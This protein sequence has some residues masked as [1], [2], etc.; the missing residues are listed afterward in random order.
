[1]GLPKGSHFWEGANSAKEPAAFP[2]KLPW[3]LLM[4]LIYLKFVSN[5]HHTLYGARASLCSS[6]DNTQ[7]RETWIN[8]HKISPVKSLMEESM[9]L[10][11]TQNC[12]EGN[13]VMQLQNKEKALCSIFLSATSSAGTKDTHGAWTPCVRHVLRW[14]R[15]WTQILECD[16]S[17]TT[18]HVLHCQES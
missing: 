9:S 6:S 15:A 3:K 13:A 17:Y 10:E 8:L 11:E 14:G 16:I 18:F 4:V 12:I 7:H 5:V 2:R 1:M